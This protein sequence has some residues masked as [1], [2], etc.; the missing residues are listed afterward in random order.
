MSSGQKLRPTPFRLRYPLLEVEWILRW[1]D[2][3]HAR[4]G[5]W[6]TEYSGQVYEAPRE[7]WKALNSALNHGARGLPHGRSL[8]RLLAEER[9]ARN[10]TNVLPLS[11]ELILS[12]ADAHFARS[13]CWPSTDSGA[14]QEAPAESWGAVNAA[15]AA[16]IRGLS[17]HTSLA[18]LL[19]EHRGVP[20]RVHLPRLTPEGILAWADAHHSRTGRWPKRHS[21]SITEAPGETWMGVEMALY[22]GNRGLPGGSSLAHLLAEHRSAR[23]K[24]ELPP[25]DLAAVLGWADAHYARTGRW[26]KPA[27]GVIPEAPG[28]TWSAVANALSK[29][30]RGLPGGS[31]LPR[32]LTEHRAVRNHLAAPRL[33]IG[34][35]EG[36][37]CA[38]RERTGE[39]PT[40]KS[41]S[42]VESPGDSWSRIDDALNQGYRGLAGGSSLARLAGRRSIQDGH[43]K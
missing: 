28:E 6:P 5:R 3:H 29:G 27:S 40:R 39:W 7:N 35:I 37:M 31:S 41:G 38:H 36:W 8:A 23:H 17:G 30:Q 9:G 14:V 18:D 4:T 16:G 11:V 25:L 21:G 19:A 13:G 43:L 24:G 15:L 26:P 34:E 32:F 22:K 20:N 10:R 42:V 33:T 1:A 2:A 12:W